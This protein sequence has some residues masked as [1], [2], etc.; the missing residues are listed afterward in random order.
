MSENKNN[1]AE[2]IE[3]TETTE[4]SEGEV[5]E[6][7]ETV[8]VEEAA[9]KIEA[10]ETAGNLEN[11]TENKNIPESLILQELPGTELPEQTQPDLSAN[12]EK[13]GF[14]FHESIFGVT[15][16]LGIIMVMTALILSLVNSLTEP[17]IEKRLAEEKAQSIVTLFGEGMEFEVIDFDYVLPVTE[18]LTVKDKSSHKLV[19][20][21]VTVSPHGFNASIVM[22]VAINPDMSV[23]DT[24]ILS[25]SETAGLGTK[26]ESEEWFRE[27][28]KGIKKNMTV[29]GTGD[30]TVNIIAGATKSSKAFISGITAA[31]EVIS[32][33]TGK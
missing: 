28:F 19:G 12:Q 15:A 1:N 29:G 23:R 8:E 10:G 31:L 5:N 33:I 20:Y 4:T 3:P 24:K 13:N 32:E 26:I 14:K 7:I 27:Q 25:M 16:I 6:A 11:A 9:D 21:C 18:A 30:S 22:I 2:N 17:V